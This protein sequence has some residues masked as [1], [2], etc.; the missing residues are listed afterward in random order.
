M[1]DFLSLEE[2]NP[3]AP[4]DLSIFKDHIEESLLGI[5]S[6]LPKVEK[7]LIVDKSCV[8]ALNY[9]TNISKLEK[10]MVRKELN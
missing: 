8:S 7:T 2:N 5:L 4:I 6:S 3:L 9:F 10:E 1:E